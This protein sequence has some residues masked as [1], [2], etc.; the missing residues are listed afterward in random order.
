MIFIR[1][2]KSKVMIHKKIPEKYD[3]FS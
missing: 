3:T 2:S 1:I